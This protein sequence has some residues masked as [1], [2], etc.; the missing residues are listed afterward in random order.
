[1]SEPKRIDTMA[2]FAKKLYELYE[3][4]GF[5]EEHGDKEERRRL[6]AMAADHVRAMKAE[7]KRSIKVG[8]GEDDKV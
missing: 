3:Q 6:T 5:D 8:G 1:V 2:E 7:A 4:F